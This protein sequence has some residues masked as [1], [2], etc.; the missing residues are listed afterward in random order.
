MHFTSIIIPVYRAENFIKR[1]LEEIQKIIN[2]IFPENEIIA[3]IDGEVDN[4]KSEALQVEGVKIYSCKI[5]QGKGH[6][7]YYGFKQ[8]TGKYVAFVDC[9]L[10]LN[11]AQLKNI[12]P[13][14]TTS[15]LVVGSKRHPFSKV[16]YPL[17]RRILSAGYSIY[18]RLILNVKLR[19]TQSGLKMAKRELLEIIM[20]LMRIKRFSFDLELCFL[21]QKH[22]FKMVEAPL[23]LTYQQ[24]EGVKSTIRIKDI[25]MM[26][27]EVI[28]IRYNFS[29][30]RLYQKSFW[31]IQNW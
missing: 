11:P 4:S 13:Y 21:A 12:E 16:H 2:N 6:A 19:D 14:L 17:L 30:R 18:S 9:D 15:D 31:E 20:P 23:N 8:S 22:G 7:L 24:F 10:D 5:I 26:F 28:T 1:N 29:I 27:Y 3:V 25:F